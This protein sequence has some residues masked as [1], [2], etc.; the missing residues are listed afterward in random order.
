[1]S[2][3]LVYPLL[4]PFATAALGLVFW[5]KPKIQQIVSLAG[6]AGHLTVSAILLATVIADGIQVLQVGNWRAPFG[7]SLVADRLSV[8]MLL[9]TGILG[10]A[11]AV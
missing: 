9:V 7:I 8:L 2:N 1:M 3:A 5:N 10:L 6:A 4:V 11:T